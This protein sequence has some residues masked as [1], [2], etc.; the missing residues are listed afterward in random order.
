MN[1]YFLAFS[2]PPLSFKDNLAGT[3]ILFCISLSIIFW[4]VFFTEKKNFSVDIAA[5]WLSQQRSTVLKITW[6]LKIMLET[7]Y[8]QCGGQVTVAQ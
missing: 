4:C 6:Q 2:M 8:S 7:L 3:V 1:E 5:Y